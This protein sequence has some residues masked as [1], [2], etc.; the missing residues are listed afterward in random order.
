MVN[1]AYV[2]PAWRLKIYDLNLNYFQA[3][4]SSF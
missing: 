3:I 4:F 2:S 1:P